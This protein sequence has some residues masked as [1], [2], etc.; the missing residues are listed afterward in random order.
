MPVPGAFRL[1]H[2]RAVARAQG[3]RWFELRASVDLARLWS[4]RERTMDAR[5]LLDAALEGY[6]DDIALPDLTDAR[7]LR[8]ALGVG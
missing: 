2:A 1:Q 4:G 5:T 8:A 3:S 7:E 6:A